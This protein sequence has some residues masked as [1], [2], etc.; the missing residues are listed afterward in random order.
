MQVH[1][2]WVWIQFQLQLQN[3]Q[4]Q[5][6]VLQ[7]Q[8]M[9]GVVSV[10]RRR[11]R[12]GHPVPVWRLFHEGVMFHKCLTT[13]SISSW[14][15]YE[16]P[17]SLSSQS[18]RAVIVVT[19]LARRTVLEERFSTACFSRPFWPRATRRSLHVCIARRL[20]E[21]I[22]TFMLISSIHFDRVLRPRSVYYFLWLRLVSL[23]F[24][25]DLSWEK[26]YQSQNVNFP[27]AHPPW[28]FMAHLIFGSRTC[29]Q[30]PWQ[31]PFNEKRSSDIV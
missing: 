19:Q 8:V 1:L 11:L 27:S 13:F 5:V 31:C 23:L 24:R 3:R 16:S 2:I 29:F 14:W 28:P 15:C 20:R 7:E 25:R 26:I 10:H 17:A 12:F 21:I 18:A 6:Q 30:R 4:L 22:F 9:L